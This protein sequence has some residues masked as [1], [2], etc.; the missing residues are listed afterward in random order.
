M[1]TC[2][3]L[4]KANEMMDDEIYYADLNPPTG[5]EQGG[6][7]PVVII[8]VLDDLRLC[9]IIPLTKVAERLDLPYTMKVNS[10]G[11]TCLPYD[12]VALIFHLRTI[13]FDRIKDKIGVL[14]GSHSKKIKYFIKTMFSIQ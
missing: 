9:S 7:R 5:H 11:S 2:R 1:G 6:I 8:K 12:S 14:E 3:N 10:T 13:S 4:P